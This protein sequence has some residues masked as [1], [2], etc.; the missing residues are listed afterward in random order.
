VPDQTDLARVDLLAALE[1][2]D[3]CQ[4]ISYMESSRC[5]T[6]KRGTPNQSAVAASLCRRTPNRSLKQRCN[7]PKCLRSH[8]LNEIF[9]SLFSICGGFNLCQDTIQLLSVQETTVYYDR[10]DL[11]GVANVFQWVAIEQDQIGDLSSLDATE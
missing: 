2:L 9:L 1:E 3:P 11:S 6:G 10:A 5:V 8:R 7:P 4:H